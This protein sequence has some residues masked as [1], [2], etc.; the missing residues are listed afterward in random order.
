MPVIDALERDGLLTRG[1][2]P[3]DRRRTPLALTPHGQ[4]V[5]RSVPTVHPDDA[6]LKALADMGERKS[7]QYIVLLRELMQ[8]VSHDAGMVQQ[9]TATSERHITRER[10]AKRA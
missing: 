8:R 5:L 3:A 1:H 7:S 4:S 10:K 9:I 6:L 2:D